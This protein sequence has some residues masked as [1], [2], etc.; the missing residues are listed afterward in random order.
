M[1]SEAAQFDLVAP[2]SL[3]AVLSLLAASPGEFAPIAGGTETMVAFGAGR[4]RTKKLVSLWG[5]PELRFIHAAPATLT[6]G[7]GSTFTDIRNHPVVASDFPMLAQ[8][9]SWTGSVANQNRGTIGGNIVNG[10]PAAD[11]PPALLAYGAEMEL[12][13]ARGPRRVAYDGFHLSYKKTALAA[14]ELVYA[15]HLPRRFAGYAQHARKVGTRNAQAISKVAIAAL[16]MMSDGTVEDIR[17]GAAS[18]RETPM[19]CKQVEG[20]LLGKRISSETI[21]EALAEA[22]AAL[23]AEV[24]PID[25]IRSTARYRAAIAGNLIEEF[26]MKLR[27]VG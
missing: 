6:I 15:I 21:K 4:L 22:R 25:D 5:L 12:V 7:A 26:L 9:A 24:L 11:S 19:R 20:T 10:S 3:D 17:I 23:A 8:A 16:A 13:S 14:D 2:G 1:R 27:P 18:L